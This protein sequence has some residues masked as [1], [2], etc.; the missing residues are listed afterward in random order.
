MNERETTHYWG[1]MVCGQVWAVG[2]VLAEGKAA[3]LAAVV[4]TVWF[5]F[6]MAI[7]TICSRGA[8]G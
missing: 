6:A 3:T 5:V 1:A 2:T 4:T 8:R 7:V